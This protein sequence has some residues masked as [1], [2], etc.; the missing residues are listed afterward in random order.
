MLSSS[1]A[2]M[3]G[4]RLRSVCEKASDSGWVRAM[5]DGLSMGLLRTVQCTCNA[6]QIAPVW[7]AKLLLDAVRGSEEASASSDMR[8]D[9]AECF[10]VAEVSQKLNAAIHQFNL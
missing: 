1:D 3:L 4:W 2:I 5:C 10:L 6:V 8:C 7:V 9:L